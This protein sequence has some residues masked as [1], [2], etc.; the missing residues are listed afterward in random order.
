METS[1]FYKLGSKILNLQ[2]SYGQMCKVISHNFYYIQEVLCLIFHVAS[3]VKK[4]F[5]KCI[6]IKLFPSGARVFLGA[7][8]YHLNKN[9]ATVERETYCM[10]FLPD[11]TK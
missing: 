10:K 1:Y 2:Y 4:I 5:F 8:L 11:Q 7:G 3:W 6:A 9:R